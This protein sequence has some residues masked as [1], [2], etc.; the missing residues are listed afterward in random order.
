MTDH[1]TELEVVNRD[2]M[3]DMTACN[4]READHLNY[5]ASLSD[6]ITRLQLENTEVHSRVWTANIV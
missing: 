5:I 1:L 4:D 6:Q 3:A 2:L